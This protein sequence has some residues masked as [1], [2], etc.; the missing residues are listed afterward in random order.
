MAPLVILVVGTLVLT[1]VG[2]LGVRVLRPWPTALRGGVA[3]MFTATGVAHFVGLRAQM[4]SMVPPALPAP[5]LLVTVTGVLEL[6]GAAGVLWPRTARWAAGGLSLMLVAMFPANV[7]AAVAG[8]LTEWNDQLVPR[9]AMQVVFLGAT[10][11]V[12]VHAGRSRA[13]EPARPLAQ[14]VP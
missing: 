7:H 5:G 10:V 3:A 2:R 9:T 14:Q 4:I 13:A 11:T 8:V 12:F 6:V 1:A